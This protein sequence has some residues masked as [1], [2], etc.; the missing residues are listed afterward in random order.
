MR[1]FAAE[2]VTRFLFPGRRK[3]W[4]PP[5]FHGQVALAGAEGTLV[6]LSIGMEHLSDFLQSLALF[7]TVGVAMMALFMAVA[8]RRH[9]DHHYHFHR[10]HPHRHPHDLN[11]GK[12]F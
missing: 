5:D 9:A 3:F 1:R 7:L 12:H 4:S 10:Q 11:V 6:A 2:C 8:P